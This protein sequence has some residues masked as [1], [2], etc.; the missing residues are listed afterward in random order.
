[1][2]TQYKIRRQL[3]MV[4]EGQFE[5]RTEQNAEDIEQGIEP[6][7][8]QIEW[9]AEVPIPVAPLIVSGLY[10]TSFTTNPAMGVAGESRTVLPTETSLESGLAGQY[11]SIREEL[12]LDVDRF[13]P[14][15]TVSGTIHR[16]MMSRTNWIASL[17]ATGPQSWTGSIWYKDG[18]T[19]YFPYTN[20]DIKTVGNTIPSNR[21]AIVRFSTPDGQSITRTF[22]YK[23]P[24]FRKLDL[25]SNYTEGEIPTTGVNTCAHPNRPA[26][27]ACEDL[28]VEQAFR[29]SGLD[30]TMN[31]GGV[32]SIPNL[33]ENRLWSDAE[34]N[35]AMKTYWSRF[36]D[37][38]SSAMWL[39]FAARH[40]DGENLGGV[41]FEN[42]GA[43]NRK[44]A[45]VFNDSFISKAP[46]DDPNPNAWA[47]RMIYWTVCH[48]IGFAFNLNRSWE[49]SISSSWLPLPDEP[50]ARSFMNYPFRVKNGEKAFFDDFE[51]KFSDSELLSMRHS[52][53]KFEPQGEASWFDNF[54]FEEARVSPNPELKLEVRVNREQPI[55]DFMEPV[56]LELK[57][58]NTSNQPQLVDNKMLADINSMTVIV[59]KDRSPA[60]RFIPYAKYLW[61]TQKHVLMPG[62]SIYEPLFISAGI[63]G[64]ETADPGNYKIQ[65]ALHTESEDYVSNTLGIRISSPAGFGE[66]YLA[67]EFFTDDVG[68]ALSFRG[69]KVMVEANNTLWQVTEKMGG[70]RVAIHANYTLGNPL[71]LNFKTLGFGQGE[72]TQNLYFNVH[73]SNPDEAKK[74]LYAALIENSEIAVETF[75][76]IDYKRRVDRFTDWLM[77]IGSTDEAVR[78]QETLFQA[79]SSR[80]VQGRRVI[81]SV[82]NDIKMRQS[83]YESQYRRA[84]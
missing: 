84:A 45:A 76:H 81:Q 17:T 11:Q 38:P 57:L 41:T 70:R 14:Q 37:R 51:Y 21:G 67:Q 66:E 62:E 23:S 2:K 40:E 82:L 68:R 48:E 8:A 53:K 25:E 63:N 9:Y 4:E 80:E 47:M 72:G 71:T 34:L 77:S 75:G 18:E 28:S 36:G 26:N 83:S 73:P 50:E 19:A 61:T 69:T 29:R 32:I 13:Y 20:I 60:R 24:Y 35:D 44:G 49:K 16:F 65:I 42:V 43:N 58:T 12:R 30:V 15:M 6:T 46:H 31:S 1:M 39:L 59:K 56:T 54:G 55:Y 27:I 64:W 52:P 78:C 3:L 5:E 22:S 79:L 74:H 33:H 10:E 7:V